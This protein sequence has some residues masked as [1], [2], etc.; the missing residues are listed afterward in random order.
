[1]YM[2]F[3]CA[4]ECGS[5]G[6]TLGS[7]PQELSTSF[8]TGSLTR[9]WG[10]LIRWGCLVTKPGDLIISTSPVIGLQVHT[11]MARLMWQRCQGHLLGKV[12][13]KLKLA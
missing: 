5:Q 7:I 9:I 13:L 1:M 4:S 12:S 2:W 3:A 10:L 11:L 8:K 6:L